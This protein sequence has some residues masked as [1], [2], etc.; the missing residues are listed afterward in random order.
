M[1]SLLKHASSS[2]YYLHTICINSFF[3]SNSKYQSTYIKTLTTLE[4]NEPVAVFLRGHAGRGNALLCLVI[5]AMVYY[6]Y[7]LAY[8]SNLISL[9]TRTNAKSQ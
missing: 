6:Y 2:S 7:F 9:S 1:Q 5:A 8:E 4:F 3:K